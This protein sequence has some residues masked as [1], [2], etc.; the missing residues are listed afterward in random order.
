MIR[1]ARYLL[2]GE[3]EANYGEDPTP[4]VA[5]A[6]NAWDIALAKLYN[7]QSH[8]TGNVSVYYD[9]LPGQQLATLSFKV[10]LSIASVAATESYLSKLLK[11]CAWSHTVPT[12][13]KFDTICEYATDSSMTFYYYHDGIL[14]KLIGARGTAKFH[15]EAGLK[16]WVEFAFT[17]LY[18]SVSAVAVP[19][20]P[21]YLETT[22][23]VVKGDEL[24][25]A[26]VDYHSITLELSDNNVVST[27]RDANSTEGIYSIE[28]VDANPEG[29]IDAMVE[30][31]N[32]ATLEALIE[33]GTDSAILFDSTVANLKV[34][35]NGI[36][37][38]RD[39]TDVEGILRYQ[40]PFVVTG[41]VD[42]DLTKPV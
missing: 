2:L 29:T 37:T 11:G 1:I 38:A 20:S 22:A 23:S 18:G 25:I 39:I 8:K 31:T 35:C 4:T 14:E 13:N 12:T 33:N 24:K 30:T 26:T 19:S 36:F 28:I 16:P 5:D 21:T 6:L 17:G 41:S 27:I 10:F 42:I 32:A 34:G 40:M 9:S 7:P 15:I 3:I